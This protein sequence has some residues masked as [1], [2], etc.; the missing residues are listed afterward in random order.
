MQD[1]V[2]K[3]EESN[4]DQSVDQQIANEREYQIELKKQKE[5]NDLREENNKLSKEVNGDVYIASSS[6]IEAIAKSKNELG[7]K[8]NRPSSVDPSVLASREIN[9][10]WIEKNE[11]LMTG[12]I[13][14]FFC[15]CSSFS[16]KKEINLLKT[17]N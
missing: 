13:F 11:N 6:D 5:L 14:V 15:Y 16:F 17:I 8:I 1:I 10:N 12:G 9:E 3:Q 2:K 7:V 4:Q